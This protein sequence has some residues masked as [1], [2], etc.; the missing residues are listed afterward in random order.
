MDPQMRRLFAEHLDKISEMPPRRH[1]KFGLPFNVENATEQAR[2][3]YE[4]EGDY[5]VV[6][7]CFVTRK[8]Y[9]KWYKSFK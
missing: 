5:L 3:V 2:L 6:V 1:L 4:I 9:E 7:Q 8:E